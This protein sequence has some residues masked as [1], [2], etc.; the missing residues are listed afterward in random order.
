M[1]SIL[2]INA[3]IINENSRKISDIFIKNGRIEQIAD[4]LSH[5]QADTII[6]ATNKYVIPGMIDD[7]V[8]FREPGLTD[9]A[10]IRSESLAGVI[11]GT[12]TYM[13]MPNNKPPIITNEGLDKKSDSSQSK[14]KFKNRKRPKNFSFNKFKKK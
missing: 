12:T 11:G 7:Q 14:K 1:K 5:I 2:I 8:H 9:K 6:D 3:T 10:D 4:K 13:D